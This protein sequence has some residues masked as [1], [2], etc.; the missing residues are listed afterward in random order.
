MCSVEP[1]APLG[2]SNT[3]YL[4]R[5]QDFKMP[6]YTVQKTQDRQRTYNV[7]HFGECS[8]FLCCPKSLTPYCLNTA[9][10]WGFNVAGAIK[11]IRSPCK[12]PDFN[13]IWIWS[14]DF[15]KV[16]DIKFHGNP[17][18][19]RRADAHG[20][21]D[22]RDK[23]NRLFFFASMQTHLKWLEC[24]NMDTVLLEKTPVS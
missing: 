21:M 19:G 23:G 7:T 5:I 8:Y 4:L 16:P 9:L 11:L 24:A 2:M 17:S 22:R 14:T 13:Q 10:V 20:Q 6:S 1:S 15:M 18:S 12:V 3:K